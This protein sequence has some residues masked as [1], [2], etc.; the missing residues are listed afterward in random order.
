MVAFRTLAAAFFAL[1]LSQATA[2]AADRWTD[3]Q[4]GPFHILSSAGDKPARERLAALE[5]LRHVLG[6]M[7]GKQDLTTVWPI[8]VV[9]FSNAKEAAGLPAFFR[10]GSA[11]IAVTNA[12][13]TVS[14]GLMRSVT[15]VLLQDN[16]T[17]MP[18]A[19]ETALEDLFSTIQVNATRVSLGAPPAL[20]AERKLQWARI[21]LFATQPA[22]S[23]KFRVYLNNLQQSG[24]DSVAVKNAF[25]LTLKESMDRAETYL[26]AS[27]AASPISG[28]PLNPAR[29]FVERPFNQV[30]E[31]LAELRNG[32][33][34]YPPES[35]RGLVAKNTHPALELAAKANPRWAEPHFLLAAMETSS[36]EKIN[37]LKLAATLEP[38]NSRYWQALAEAQAAAEQFA[39]AARSWASAEK[40]AATPEE[41]EKVHKIRMDAEERRT[42]TDLASRRNLMELRAKELEEI[43]R[44]AAAEVHAAEEAANQRAGGLKSTQAAVQ[45]WSD[46]D[47]VKL[48]GTLQRVDCMNGSLRLAVQPGAGSAVQILIRDPSK[49]A[50]KDSTGL[51]LSCGP[52]RPVRKIELVHNGRPDGSMSTVGDA[53]FVDMP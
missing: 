35:P 14:A 52:Q 31:L 27:P 26:K 15:Q 38:R 12:A 11:T 18:E 23:G 41:R 17:Q 19:I 47:G 33:N 34:N 16:A 21:Q 45:W 46:Q 9:L 24:E 37:Q 36:V 6:G 8:Q 2:P 48:S 51:K 25:G 7:L 39:D 43:K 13:D 10:G 5:Q 1:V 28:K 44:E 3:Y 42:E 20:S 50:V 29:D 40:A 32:K 49:L 30:P 22:F 4:A 53:T